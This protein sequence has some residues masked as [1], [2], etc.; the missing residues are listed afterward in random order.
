[1]YRTLL[2]IR[3][4]RPAGSRPARFGDVESDDISFER[5]NPGASCGLARQVVRVGTR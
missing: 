3:R 4:R 5:R 2:R 1:M